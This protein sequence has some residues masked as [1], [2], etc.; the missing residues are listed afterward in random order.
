MN[1][2]WTVLVAGLVAGTALASYKVQRDIP[3]QLDLTDAAGV[4][5]E[6]KCDDPSLLSRMVFYYR[7]GSG[8]YG[9]RGF[10][11]DKSGEWQRIRMP[12]LTRVELKPS[13]WGKIDAVR[14]AA[15]FRDKDRTCGFDIRNIT[16]IRS[17][18]A[19][20]MVSPFSVASTL[21]TAK[22]NGNVSLT[23]SILT[24][25]PVCSDR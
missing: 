1:K 24:S 5:F 22:F 19:E 8:W 21:S 9:N 15:V 4:T 10:E 3:V 13:G 16:P 17:D 20:R 12:K 25:M 18:S 11:V 2:I 6:A 7:S 23:R 14:L